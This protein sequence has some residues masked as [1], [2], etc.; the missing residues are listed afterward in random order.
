MNSRDPN[1]EMLEH[2]A[3]GLGD[4][5]LAD[6][7]FV[8]G[9]VAGL[10]VTDPAQPAIRPTDDVDVVVQVLAI[11][12]YR[13]IEKR[14]LG[15]GLRQDMSEEAPIC[16]WRFEGVAVDVMPTLEQV[17]GFSNRWYPL[18]VDTAGTLQLPSGRNIRT[19]TAPAFIATKLEAFEHRGQNDFLLSHDLGDIIAIVDGRASLSAEMSSVQ[20]ALRR[21][22][23]ERFR[24]FLTLPQFVDALP[25]HLPGDAASQARQPMILSIVEAIANL[26]D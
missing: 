2:V 20:P 17:L 7:V 14:L 8:G 19:I 3:R 6:V 25:G 4:Q 23:A 9:A 10:L 21:Y 1:I 11:A 22:V 16:R 5:L 24:T 15:R 12:D 26:G 13:E 18:A